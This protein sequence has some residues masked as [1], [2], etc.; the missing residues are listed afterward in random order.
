MEDKIMRRHSRA[1]R[2]MAV[3]HMKECDN[4]TEMSE[5]LGIHR[6]LLYIW[7]ERLDPVDPIEEPPPVNSR[8]ITLRKEISKLK[9]HLADK[10]VE[11]DFFKGALH[12]VKARRQ[13]RE[14]PGE[15]AYTSRSGK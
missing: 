9:H 1:F 2:Q 13:Q 15:K 4:I 12:K 6:R 11:A 14:E 5:E 10:S 3:E 8:E 7:R